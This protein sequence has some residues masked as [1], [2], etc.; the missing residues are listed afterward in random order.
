LIRIEVEEY[1]QQC[2]DFVPDVTAPERVMIGDKEVVFQTDT[3]IR[4]E[5]RR[6]CAGITRYLEHQ[7]KG[8]VDKHE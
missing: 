8:D 6:R 2:A 3:V 1:C 4:C 5:Y 7:I